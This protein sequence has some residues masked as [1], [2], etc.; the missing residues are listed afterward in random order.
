MLLICRDDNN[1]AV[2]M[3]MLMQN[4]PVIYGLD[5]PCSVE[6]CISTFFR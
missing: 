3:L 2:V 6:F 1:D 4:C 5:L